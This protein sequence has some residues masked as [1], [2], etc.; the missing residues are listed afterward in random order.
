MYLLLYLSI[1]IVTFSVISEYVYDIYR[2]IISYNYTRVYIIIL[3]VL[4]LDY[5]IL[6]H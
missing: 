3:F 4:Y 2:T 6:F 5:V 1:H